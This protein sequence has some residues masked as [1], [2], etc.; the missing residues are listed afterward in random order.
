MRTIVEGG[1][2]LKRCSRMGN[3][4]LYVGVKR[5]SGSILFALLFVF[6]V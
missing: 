6:C 1:A 4:S 3:V 2:A 5:E